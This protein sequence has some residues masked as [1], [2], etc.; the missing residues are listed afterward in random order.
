MAITIFLLLFFLGY[1]VFHFYYLNRGSIVWKMRRKSAS[2]IRMVKEGEYVKIVGQIIP[3][4][5][6][7]ISP[8]SERPC[9]F[10]HVLVREGSNRNQN[11]LI[12]HEKFECFLI[13]DGTGLL[14]IDPTNFMTY[15][16]QDKSFS[17]GVFNNATPQLKK[18]LNKFKKKS[19]AVWGLNKTLNYFEGAM[20]PSEIVAAQGY[21]KWV[22]AE[23]LKLSQ[24]Y[25][26]KK[27]LVLLTGKEKKYL[28]NDSWAKK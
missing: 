22:T 7:L 2:S 15:L 24:E 9:V 17:S 5:E 27:I 13:D 18:F 28:S 21:A 14:F 1:V 20:E 3:I 8:L 19:V 26:G 10:Y 16:V 12:D 25:S 6:L 4:S 23:S 11:T